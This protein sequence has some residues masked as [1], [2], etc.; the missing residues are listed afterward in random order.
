MLVSD[1]ARPKGGRPAAEALRDN[2]VTRI[3]LRYVM[4]AIATSRSGDATSRFLGNE[5]QGLCMSTDG[6]AEEHFV[7]W[8]PDG[9]LAIGFDDDALPL[10]SDRDCNDVEAVLADIPEKLRPLIIQLKKPQVTRPVTSA[11]WIEVTDRGPRVSWSHVK[12]EQLSEYELPLEEALSAWMKETSM[13]EPHAKI[14]LDLV[15]AAGAER[16]VSPEQS[17]ALLDP[18]HRDG[19]APNPENVERAIAL[20]REVG[21]EWPDGAAHAARIAG[22]DSDHGY[23]LIDAVASGDRGAVE[24]LIAKGANLQKRSRPD[25]DPKARR[26]GKTPLAV[27][28]SNGDLAMVELLLGAGADPLDS[29]SSFSAILDVAATAGSRAICELLIA[30]GAPTEHFYAMA[31]SAESPEII[32]L[33]IE[34]GVTEFLV[35]AWYDRLRAACLGAGRQ[36]LLERCPHYEA[37]EKRRVEAHDDV[38]R[39][40]R[41]QGKEILIYVWMREVA[42]AL[43]RLHFKPKETSCFEGTAAKGRYCFM[44]DDKERHVVAWNEHGVVVWAGAAPK[45]G[46]TMPPASMG[47]RASAPE[48]LRKLAEETATSWELSPKDMAEWKWVVPEA[49]DPAAITA[50]SLIG[51][52]S[53]VR[54]Y[55]RFWDMKTRPQTENWPRETYKLNHELGQR[56]ERIVNAALEG[57]YELTAEDDEA[58]REDQYGSKGLKPKELPG[59]VKML[60]ALGIHWSI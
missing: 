27:A 44:P 30:R 49:D 28:V 37:M 50:S 1:N 58:F 4:H 20:L 31:I 15:Q 17:N 3:R 29:G 19:L 16:R 22:D 56:I 34:L 38:L 21:I 43:R 54:R 42:L 36:D 41:S 26:G 12:S 35:P 51:F 18:A 40:L 46:D 9:V 32:E 52:D 57:P 47:L 10:F 33:A 45:P 39:K 60:A 53:P 25:Q 7:A 24:A 5:A 14:A 59:A 48:E 55:G 8:S 6:N 13:P 11:R 2:Y 23:S